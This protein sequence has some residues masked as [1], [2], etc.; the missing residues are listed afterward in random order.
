[1]PADHS[2]DC[3]DCGH[4]VV[5]HHHGLTS[6]SAYDSI[7]D[8]RLLWTV[9]LNQLLTV[10]QVIAGIWSGSVALLSDAA[11]NFSDAN[12]LLIAYIARRISRRKAS[13][14]FTFGYRRAELIGATIN[15]TLLATVGC[16][17]IYE[18]A[19]RLLDPQ[20][21]IG[22]LM[23]AAAAIALV[24][25]I[26]TAGLLWAMSRGSLNVRAAFVHNLVDAAGSAVVLIGAVVITL[27][28]WTWVDSAL[29]FGLAIY[30]LY[31]VWS[32]LPQAIRIL[33]EGTPPDLDVD[34]LIRVAVEMP[35]VVGI[36][37]LHVWELDEDHRALEAHVSIR[38]DDLDRMEDIKHQ[39][40]RRLHEAFDIQHS[41]L[42]FE[43]SR[44]N[45]TGHCTEAGHEGL[46]RCWNPDLSPDGSASTPVS[47]TSGRGK[48]HH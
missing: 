39:L 14:R 19:H 9:A 16:F 34:E 40:K 36:H 11:H 3:H 38:S 42:E 23:G 30:I 18:A 35:D 29:T 32:M 27:T 43:V 12:A 37:H 28:D 1:M 44:D 46:E 48:H 26:A 7:P 5:P 41:T 24:I 33:M 47:K 4:G 2:H 22:W 8:S 10:A 25:D 6:G 17:L 15:L 21:V 31:Q 20:P 13:S 45:Q